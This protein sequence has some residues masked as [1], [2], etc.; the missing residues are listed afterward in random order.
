MSAKKDLGTEKATHVFKRKFKSIKW[1][2]LFLHLVFK[3][4]LMKYVNYKEI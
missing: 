4:K 2:R 3:R 1:T